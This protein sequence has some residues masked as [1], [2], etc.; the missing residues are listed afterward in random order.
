VRIHLVHAR[1]F[2]NFFCRLLF[3]AHRRKALLQRPSLREC[4]EPMY[5][6]HGYISATLGIPDWTRPTG[7]LGCEGWLWSVMCIPYSTTERR[8]AGVRSLPFPPWLRR[9]PADDRERLR[10]FHDS[11]AWCVVIARMA[12]IVF[13][14]QQT[15]AGGVASGD[16]ASHRTEEWRVRDG[17][18]WPRALAPIG[19][20][21]RGL[22]WWRRGGR[23]RTRDI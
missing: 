19:R 3:E 6:M 23:A 22:L 8:G 1:T 13:S 5:D 15:A 2:L 18:A 7:Q 17:A 12:G 14:G 11:K 20:G 21:G 4:P 16:V 10:V 9:L